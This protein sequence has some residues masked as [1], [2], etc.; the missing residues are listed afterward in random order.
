M[1][2][3]GHFSPG[4]KIKCVNLL[5]LDGFNS[6]G[7]YLDKSSGIGRGNECEDR[8]LEIAH[9]FVPA[10]DYMDKYFAVII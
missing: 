6:V 7:C 2:L 1:R 10:S 3:T 8:I 5:K 4:E 9:E